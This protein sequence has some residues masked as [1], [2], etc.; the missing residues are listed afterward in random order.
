[1]K[2]DLYATGKMRSD[3]PEFNVRDPAKD[4]PELRCRRSGCRRRFFTWTPLEKLRFV[5]CDHPAVFAAGE[6]VALAARA[7]ETMGLIRR[8]RHCGQCARR[9]DWLNRVASL[10]M[11]AWLFHL[12]RWIVSRAFI[13]RWR[14]TA[15]AGRLSHWLARLGPDSPSVQQQEIRPNVAMQTHLLVD[16]VTAL[17][18]PL[19]QQAALGPEDVARA[20]FR[21]NERLKAVAARS[22]ATRPPERVEPLSVQ[23]PAMNDSRS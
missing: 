16:E 4:S 7:V 14:R 19:V 13:L 12:S 15:L 8:R 21:V 17:L 9:R 20:M 22:Q 5:K 2:C 23:S 11:P 18:M 10:P 6:V 1:M 3:Y